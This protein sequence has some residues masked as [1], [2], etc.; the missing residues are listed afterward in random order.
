MSIVFSGGDLVNIAID[1]ERRGIMFY[2]IMAKST[3]NEDARAVFEGLV[4]MEREHI[5]IFEDM[6]GEA[7]THQPKDAS[8]GGYSDYLQ[9]LVDE[10]VFSD[11]MI[12]S[13]MA[14]QADS[15]VKALELGIAAEKDSILF[16]YEM[17]DIMPRGAVPLINRI[18]AEEK[19]HL[20]QLSDIKKK[21][22]E[23]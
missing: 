12:T 22:S 10:A 9:A 6:L 1:I 2:D 4:E 8:S 14:T 16:Y 5:R 15:D 18:I 11:D 19:S 21:L 17:R 13:E 3:D 20:Q 23:S 7:D